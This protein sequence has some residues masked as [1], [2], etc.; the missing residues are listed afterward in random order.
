MPGSRSA[1][2][3]GHRPAARRSRHPHT[4][5]T[6]ARNDAPKSAATPFAAPRRAELETGVGRKRLAAPLPALRDLQH[7]WLDGHD[8]AIDNVRRRRLRKKPALE[9]EQRVAALEAGAVVA[10]GAA[11]E[12]HRAIGPEPQ[13]PRSVLQRR[14]GGD[15]GPVRARARAEVGPG[16]D[17][18]SGPRGTPR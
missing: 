2:Q 16:F 15:A 5:T 4:A 14:F 8:A 17:L 11:D 1:G 12:S 18:P 13:D 10:A 7:G 9:R 3:P 6:R